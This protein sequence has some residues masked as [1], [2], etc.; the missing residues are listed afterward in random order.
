MELHRFQRLELYRRHAAGISKE[1]LIRAADSL[2][3]GA[4]AARFWR[5]RGSKRP[6]IDAVCVPAARPRKACG[7]WVA[8]G[9]L[10]GGDGGGSSSKHHEG[11]AKLAFIAINYKTFMEPFKPFSSFT[12]NCSY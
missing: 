12:I 6:R 7:L 5:G 10:G 4:A 2:C 9:S 11:R 8:A 3:G 1:D